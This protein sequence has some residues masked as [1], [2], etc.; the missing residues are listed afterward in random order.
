MHNQH[1]R[2]GLFANNSVCQSSD[3]SK[4]GILGQQYN[5]VEEMLAHYYQPIEPSREIQF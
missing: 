4:A 5:M 3:L 1:P 2:N